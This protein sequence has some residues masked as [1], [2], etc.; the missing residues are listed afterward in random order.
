VVWHSG[1]TSKQCN[2]IERIQKRACRIIF[3]HK[4][5]SYDAAIKSC[6]LDYLSDRREALCLKF[7]QGL[8]SNVRTSH[9]IPP[10]RFE[11]H[12][13]NLR[14]SSEISKLDLRTVRFENSPVPF[15]INLLNQ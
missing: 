9:L 7:A 3:G 2:D 12:G 13:K 6:K 11:C 15:F 14:N 8:S 1:I 5:N 4:Y 10:T